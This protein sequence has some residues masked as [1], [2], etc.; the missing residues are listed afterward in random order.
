VSTTPPSDPGD[1]P[2]P[3]AYPP[4]PVSYPPPSGGYPTG[5]YAGPAGG[6]WQGQSA[7]PFGNLAGWWSR[8]GATVID[9]FLIGIGARVLFAVLGASGLALGVA[10]QAVFLV[11]LI[12]MI[13]SPRGQ[14]VGM[15]AVG[16]RAVD[17]LTGG[18]LGYSRATM[19]ILIS[20]AQGVG[21]VIAV[22]ATTSPG[23]RLL[24][25]FLL[26]CV[27]LADDL[28]PLWD[29]RRQTLHDKVAGSVVLRI[30]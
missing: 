19:R 17:A 3:G 10:E 26:G 24:L 16:N 21:A 7:V 11:Y 20:L 6:G 5:G 13:G 12:L 28:W 1:D 4:P 25:V 8:V 30:R 22:E 23:S 18:V 2:E 15:M 29:R 9:S 14:T 27:A